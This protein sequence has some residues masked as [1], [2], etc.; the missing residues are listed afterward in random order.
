LRKAEQRRMR[1]DATKIGAATGWEAT[2]PLD[3]SLAQML[4]HWENEVRR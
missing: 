1:G 4:E 3:A 2:T